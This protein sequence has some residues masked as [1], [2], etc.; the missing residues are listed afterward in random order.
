MLPA[1]TI[2][3]LLLLVRAEWLVLA[4]AFLLQEERTGTPIPGCHFGFKFGKDR[5]PRFHAG[6][7]LWKAKAPAILIVRFNRSEFHAPQ[8]HFVDEAVTLQHSSEKRMIP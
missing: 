7:L 8:V 5:A 4:L 6:F 2:K 1:L 3:R